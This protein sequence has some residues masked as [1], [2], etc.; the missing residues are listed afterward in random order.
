M[1]INN[2]TDKASVELWKGSEDNLESV[3]PKLRARNLSDREIQHTHFTD[4]ETDREA[5]TCPR[6]ENVS[7][8]KQKPYHQI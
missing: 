6:E 5:L 4:T 2:A 8:T 1:F 3:L 7:N